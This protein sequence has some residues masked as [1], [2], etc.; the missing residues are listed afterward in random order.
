MHPW[1]ASHRRQRAVGLQVVAE[2]GALRL[3]PVAIFVVL[4]EGCAQTRRP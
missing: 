4:S 1:S 2:T 3:A